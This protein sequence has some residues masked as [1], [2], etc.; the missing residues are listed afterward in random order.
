VSTVYV[1]PVSF[2]LGDLV[3][4]L[5]AVQ[6]LIGQG[7]A[8]WLVAR[9]AV[10]AAIADRIDGLS[11][12]VDADAVDA[13]AVHRMDG[14]ARYVDLRD[15]P[16]QRDHWWGSAAFEQA[17]PGFRINDIV[18]RMCVDFGISADLT[19]PVPL[20]SF[21]RPELASS[22]VFVMDTDGP[23]K[24]WAYHRW[25]ALADALGEAGVEVCALARD[26]SG[27]IGRIE[28]VAAPTPG[29]V[30]DVL[31]SARAVVG[32]D[33]GPSHLAVQQGTP[34]VTICRPGNVYL[35][36][37]AHSRAV[38]GDPCDPACVASEGDYA[39][40]DRV[41]L[42]GFEW[43]PRRCPVDGR[44]LDAVRVDAVL[45]ALGEIM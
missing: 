6:G 42:R 12:C 39:Y 37:W 9:S 30:V 13:D 19:R 35:R 40:N 14:D 45:Q 25:L 18:G 21:R 44:C 16:L 24:R 22:V 38:I 11:G 3:V 1:A 28:P 27:G 23:A 7:D 41:D 29:D 10:Q 31:T 33:S 2:G 15:H 5:P 34:T 4:S 17:Y 43:Q 26:E 32:V 20:T 8:T 36:P